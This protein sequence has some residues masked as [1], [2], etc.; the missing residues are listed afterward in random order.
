MTFHQ[1]A[2]GS[3]LTEQM[4]HLQSHAAQVPRWA[5][6]DMGEENVWSA[7]SKIW[8][9]LLVVLGGACSWAQ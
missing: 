1:D 6:R 7:L 8:F 2:I 5:A 3:N 9:E 4:A